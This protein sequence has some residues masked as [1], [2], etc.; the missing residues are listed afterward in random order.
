MPKKQISHIR[1]STSYAPLHS[2]IENDTLVIRIDGK[3]RSE[4]T[5]L[6]QAVS[7][8]YFGPDSELNGAPCSVPQTA[9]TVEKAIIHAANSAVDKAAMVIERDAKIQKVIIMAHC[10]WLVTH[11]NDKVWEWLA[12]GF[13]SE[14]QFPAGVSPEEYKLAHH[15][16]RQLE[17]KN[18]AVLFWKVVERLIPQPGRLANDHLD[19]LER[20]PEEQYKWQTSYDR[21]LFMM[22][23]QKMMLE[24]AEA[25]GNGDRSSNSGQP[26]PCPN[27]GPAGKEI[28]KKSREGWRRGEDNN[29]PCADCREF[30]R[31]HGD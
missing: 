27:C 7:G 29:C 13:P 11:M 1:H 26:C 4:G 28:A 20:D 17:Q 18:I 23:I 31:T 30:A 10:D 21:Y 22:M 5:T 16:V 25:G 8:R 15:I 2:K 6:A 3:A 9:Q 12:H 24:E 14:E 19:L